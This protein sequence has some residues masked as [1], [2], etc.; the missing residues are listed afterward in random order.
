VLLSFL[1]IALQVE[2]LGRSATNAWFFRP[3]VEQQHRYQVGLNFVL[4]MLPVFAFQFIKLQYGVKWWRNPSRNTFAKFYLTSVV[5]YLS[6]AVELT[7][8]LFVT[9][10]VLSDHA[11]YVGWVLVILVIPFVFFLQVYMRFID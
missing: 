11:R 9:K 6:L 7:L 1:W 3:E 4:I 5:Y 2:L 10:N 8:V